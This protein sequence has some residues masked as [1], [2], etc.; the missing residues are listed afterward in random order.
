MSN[1]EEQQTAIA[2][3][4]KSILSS[5]VDAS[6][7][8][9][10]TER[11]I[12]VLNVA[13]SVSIATGQPAEYL[14]EL[15]RRLRKIFLGLLVAGGVL[16]A[17]VIGLG[18]YLGRVPAM[19]PERPLLITFVG[20]FLAGSVFC[21]VAAAA[22]NGW[23]YRRRLQP[24]LAGLSDKADVS[25]PTFV[26]IEYPPN[27]ASIN[28]V[29]TSDVGYVFCAPVHRRIVIEGILLRHVIRAEDVVDVQMVEAA[30]HSP[31]G[32]TRALRVHFRIGG[33]AELIV[34]M[35]HESLWGDFVRSV[36]RRDR[37]LESVRE[38][39]GRAR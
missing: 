1:F 34:G 18:L 28:D 36:T 31:G 20:V 23:F 30:P 35:Q 4:L 7:K 14:G 12:D 38:A 8:L 22:G 15:F 24:Q 10:D 11:P 16:L 5:A 32:P 27:V 2:E 17:G 6:K 33:E 13:H 25:R 3:F 21:F 39:L 29:I 37:L 26:E 9:V 19:A